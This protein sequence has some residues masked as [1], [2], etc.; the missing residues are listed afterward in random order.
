VDATIHTPID[1]YREWPVPSALRPMVSAIWSAAPRTA[2]ALVTPDNSSDVILQLYPDG[3][4]AR[5]VAV[6][7][8]S[9]PIAV[10]ASTLPAFGVRFRP[11]WA[12]GV[13][14]VPAAELRDD[15]VPLADLHPELASAVAGRVTSLDIVSWLSAAVG[16]VAEQSPG[17]PPLVRDAL[18][19][20]ERSGG[21]V[22]IAALAGQAQRSRQQLAR[23]FDEWVGVSPKFASRVVR[24]ARVCADARPGAPDRWSALA[25]AY[26]FADQSHL[27]RE[28]RAL[29]G[30]TPGGRG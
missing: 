19:E 15:V 10:Q 4:V 28:M 23:A 13:L 30:V 3:S 25:Y 26:G 8:M 5:A 11:G 9:R 27:V 1:D 24:I 6:G 20:I 29:R 17:P 21:A 22:R 2:P 14:G 16:R 7:T 12:R 18:A